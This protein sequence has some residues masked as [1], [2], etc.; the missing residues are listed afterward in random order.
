M[1]KQIAGALAGAGALALAAAVG[2]VGTAVAA[3]NGPAKPVND[4]RFATAGSATPTYGTRTIPHWSFTY[5][6]PTDGHSY[7]A[8]MV[9]SDPRQGGSTTI[10]TVIVPLQFNF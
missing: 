9:G 5:T 3:S 8:T 2:P 4:A 6:D 1:R 7:T 10:H